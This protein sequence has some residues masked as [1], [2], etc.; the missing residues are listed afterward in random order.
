[1]KNF[2]HCPRCG[3]QQNLDETRFCTKCGLEISDVKELMNS[4]SVRSKSEIEKKRV[5]AIKQGMTMIFSGFGLL[6][7][8]AALRDTF[9]FAKIVIILPFLILMLGGVFRMI[10]SL[11]SDETEITEKEDRTVKTKEL[12]GEQNTEKSL[13]EAENRPPLDFETKTFDTNE[14]LEPASVTENTTR[15]LKKEL[16]QE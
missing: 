2:I 16:K 5:K 1:M 7:I 6:M 10:F 15:K 3:H 9:S 11:F 8:M 4:G 14:L 13:P 12:S